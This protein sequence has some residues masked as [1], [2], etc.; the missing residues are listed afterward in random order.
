[1]KGMSLSRGMWIDASFT[2]GRPRK[3]PRLSG[4]RAPS[5]SRVSD[6]P[7]AT[8]EVIKVWVR[9]AKSI[10]MPMPAYSPARMP[11]SAEPVV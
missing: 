6:S 11:S 7:V 5:P 9:K 4:P 1:M 3:P 8:C 10:D 2:P